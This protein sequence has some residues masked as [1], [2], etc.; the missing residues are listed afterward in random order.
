MHRLRED[1][2]LEEICGAHILVALRSA[3]GQF[4]FAMQISGKS[5]MMWKSVREGLPEEVIL[6]RLQTQYGLTRENA[7]KNYSRF[8]TYCKKKNYFC[9]EKNE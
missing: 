4:P 3:W 7:E 5:A 9:T 1:V 8:I 6:D 2:V